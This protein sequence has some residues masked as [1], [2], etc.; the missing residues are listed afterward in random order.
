MSKTMFDDLE[1][2]NRHSTPDQAVPDPRDM[3]TDPEAAS[4]IPAGPRRGDSRHEPVVVRRHAALS[5]VLGLGASMLSALYLVRAADDGTTLSWVIGLG[6]AV[7]AAFHLTQWVDARTP[8]LLIDVTG[9]RLR[10][11]NVWHGLLWHD[12]SRVTV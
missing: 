10:L 4:V 6:L 8:L 3:D 2:T 7:L 11:G 1:T 12:V 9:V 5:A